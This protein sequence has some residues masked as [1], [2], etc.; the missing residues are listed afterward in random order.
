[1]SVS[2]EKHKKVKPEIPSL[3]A[4]SVTLG[5]SLPIRLPPKPIC[6]DRDPT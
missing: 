3:K 1:M 2:T 6:K 4:W 5:K